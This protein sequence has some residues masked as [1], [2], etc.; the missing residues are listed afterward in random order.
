METRPT[1]TSLEIQ[2]IQ[3]RNFETDKST[4]FR[5]VTSVLQDLGYT[6]QAADLDTGIVTANS[7]TKK[8]SSGAAA[9]NEVFGGLRTEGKTQVTATVEEFGTKQSRVR[10]NFVEQR[11][12]S[13]RSG[14]TAT[15]EHA[16]HDPA[17]YTNAFE[18][19]GEA[20]FVREAQR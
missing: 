17:I 18:K 9:L 13:T 4:A 20:I 16:V 2:A 6:I 1:K 5:S 10:L 12:R 7:P 3:A 15:D 11:F 8:D 14:Q 19:I